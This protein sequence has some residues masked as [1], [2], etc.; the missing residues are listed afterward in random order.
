MSLNAFYGMLH[1]AFFCGLRAL[2]NRKKARIILML[3]RHCG[4]VSQLLCSATY[5]GALTLP[6]SPIYLWEG[7]NG[8]LSIGANF[9]LFGRREAIFKFKNSNMIYFFLTIVPGRPFWGRA[10]TTPR[11]LL[12]S[13]RS[14]ILIIS[15]LCVLF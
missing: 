9:F 7:P 4:T 15:S 8:L 5:Q 11:R 14:F 3:W 1:T 13:E 10:P 12:S 2:N 6:P